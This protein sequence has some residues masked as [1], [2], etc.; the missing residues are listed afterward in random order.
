MSKLTVSVG[1]KDFDIKLDVEFSKFFARE[2]KETFGG[3]STIETKELLYAFVQ[4][5]HDEYQS[6][7]EYKKIVDKIDKSYFQID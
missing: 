5:S 4:K 6:R 7:Q 1:S 3:K 2:F